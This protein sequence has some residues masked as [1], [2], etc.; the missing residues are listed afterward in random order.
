MFQ[1]SFFAPD[2]RSD[3]LGNSEFASL[4]FANPRSRCRAAPTATTA[5]LAGRNGDGAIRGARERDDA[6][7]PAG[8]VVDTPRAARVAL[9]S[10][11]RG[12]GAAGDLRWPPMHVATAP[13]AGPLRRPDARAPCSMRSTPSACAATAG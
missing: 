11:A 12:A 9:A 13:G 6:E 10:L 4:A 7:E 8:V 3:S 2:S 1:D 5:A